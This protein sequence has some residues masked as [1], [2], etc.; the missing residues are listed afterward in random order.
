MYKYLT[1][2]QEYALATE[3]VVGGHKH[4]AEVNVNTR[5]G[6]AT[7]KSHTGKTAIVTRKGKVLKGKL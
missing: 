6:T 7:V 4:W 5:T 2:A 3:T 1:Q